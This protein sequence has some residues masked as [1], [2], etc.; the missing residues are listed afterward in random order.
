MIMKKLLV[1]S[2]MVVLAATSVFA[3]KKDVKTEE[4]SPETPFHKGSSTLALG[5]GLGTTWSYA[6]YTSVKSIPA[7]ALYFDHGIKDN[8]GP[9]NLGVGG[10]VGYQGSSS[11]Y[12]IAGKEYKS[13]WTNIIVAVRATYHL[14]LLADKNNKFD[15]YGGV[16]AG[17]RF[18]GWSDTYWNSGTAIGIKPV[19]NP[20]YA[21][22]GLF[23]GAKYNFS[24]NFGAWAELGY[25]IAFL[26]LGINLNF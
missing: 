17:V 18:A 2:C 15:P 12:T 14:T 20:V 10:L 11:K 8:L 26:K 9:G 21:A 13:T 24:S 6:G 23:V 4:S 7:I 5:L 16:M 22:T 19:Y 1:T 3:Q 25:D